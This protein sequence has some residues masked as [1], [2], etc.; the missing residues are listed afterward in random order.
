MMKKIASLIVLIAVIFTSCEEPIYTPK[1]RAFPKINFPEAANYQQFDQDFCEFTFQYPDYV[2]VIQDKT[3]FEDTPPNACWFD[4]QVPAL[5]S[6]IHFTYYPI[7]KSADFQ[8]L[9][10]DA[11]RLAQEHNKKANYID[12]LPIQKEKVS[13]YVFDIDGEVASPF[14]FYLTDSTQH[15]LRGALYFDAQAR[16]DSLAPAY[17]FMKKEI[18]KMIDTFEWQAQ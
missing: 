8:Q 15:F 16:P 2:K 12:E 4:L 17:D 1:P 11:F 18:L 13:G 7:E 10:E 3:F 5:E 14:Q 9:R 6:K